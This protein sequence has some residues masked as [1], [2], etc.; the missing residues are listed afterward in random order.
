MHEKRILHRNNLFYYLKVFEMNTNT[1]LGHLVD[2]TSEGMMLIS[3]QPI[4]TGVVYDLRLE[5]P[6][7]IFGVEILDFSA[8]SLWTKPDTNPELHD[9]GFQLIDVPFEH[10]LLIK[11]LVSEFGFIS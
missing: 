7:N 11:R 8:H 4:P 3:E 5:F 6:K 10:I 9:T 1:L 2:I